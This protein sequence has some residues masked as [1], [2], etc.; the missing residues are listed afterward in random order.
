MANLAMRGRYRERAFLAALHG[1]KLDE[2]PEWNFGFSSSQR[3]R[4]LEELQAY[5]ARKKAQQR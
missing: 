1:V 2:E 5:I 3:E 4:E